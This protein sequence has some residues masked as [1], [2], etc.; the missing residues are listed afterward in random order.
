M[1]RQQVA[2]QSA[3]EGYA[4]GNMQGGLPWTSGMNQPMETE[5]S[6]APQQANA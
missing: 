6:D 2:T 1:I 5:P 4:E 3:P